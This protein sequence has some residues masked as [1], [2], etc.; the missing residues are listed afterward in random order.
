MSDT[1]IIIPTYNERPNVTPIAEAVLAIKLGV[2][3]QDLAETIHAH[4][5]LT[6]GLWEVSRKAYYARY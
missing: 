3:T 1:L 2:T 5:T 6:E 4:P